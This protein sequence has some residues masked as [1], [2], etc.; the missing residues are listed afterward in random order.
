MAPRS[1]A[2]RSLRRV[3]FTG[4]LLPPAMNIVYTPP[5]SSVRV[6][7]V[8]RVVEVVVSMTSTSLFVP[9]ANCAGAEAVRGDES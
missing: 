1:C 7:F 8:N 6:V 4:E 3:P 9:L 5:A 2:Q